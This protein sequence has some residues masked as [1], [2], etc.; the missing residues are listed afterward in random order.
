M[1][2][3]TCKCLNV[4]LNIIED[5]SEVTQGTLLLGQDDAV[6]ESDGLGLIDEFFQGDL[7]I[8]T[9]AVAGI[10]VQQNL[11]IKERIVNDYR[12]FKCVNCDMSTHAVHK[13]KGLD[14]VVASKELGD[15]LMYNTT[16]ESPDYS[17][18]F[19]IILNTSVSS[20]KADNDRD[21]QAKMFHRSLSDAH[22]R[23]NKIVEKF[24][25][26]EEDAMQERIRIFTEQQKVLFTG[27]QKKIT[28]DKEKFLRLV[29]KKE[30]TALQTSLNDAMKEA[31]LFKSDS[32]ESESEDV[33]PDL[34]QIRGKKMRPNRFMFSS[35]TQDAPSSLPNHMGPPKSRDISKQL[36]TSRNQRT[37]LAI[38]NGRRRAKTQVDEDTLFDLDGFH[39]NKNCEPFFESDEES[40]DSNSLDSSGG[41]TI[42]NRELAGDR[43]YATSVPVGIP[44]F[45]AMKRGSFDNNAERHSEPRLSPDKIAESMKALAKSLHDSTSIFG[46][47]PT[48]RYN[49]MPYK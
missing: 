21:T 26:N 35:S 9:L 22:L 48:P 1:T 49:T 28:D 14:R 10:E 4:S 12:V 43:I 15:A 18:V 13:F 6:V 8:I 41:Y 5:R 2:K 34:P 11:L 29:S 7:T 40:N 23:V 20:N 24:L 45:H 31:T 19:K 30:E 42:P 46:E 44:M 38:T 25:V 37:S 32:V 39:E 17:P 47:L 3:L 27:L 16:R 33:A 36:S